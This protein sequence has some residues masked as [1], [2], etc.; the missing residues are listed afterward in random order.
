M[1]KELVAF[2]IALALTSPYWGGMI[3]M[4]LYALYD[5]LKECKAYLATI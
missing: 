4:D 5:H 2:I 3:L 1:D